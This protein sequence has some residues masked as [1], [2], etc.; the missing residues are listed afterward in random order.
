MILHEGAVISSEGMR[1]P[2]ELVRHK[3]MD[4]VGDMYLSGKRVHAHIV[5]VRPGHPSNVE[6]VKRMLAATGE[7][8]AGM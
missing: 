1:F 4:M 7:L 5:A 2:N 8:P 6:T 3:M